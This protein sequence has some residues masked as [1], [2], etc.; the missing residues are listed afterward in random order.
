MFVFCGLVDGIV[1]EGSPGVLLVCEVRPT[2]TATRRPSM[3]VPEVMSPGLNWSE[4]T[5]TSSLGCGWVDGFG[6]KEENACD[7]VMAAGGF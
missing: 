7:C 4:P 1:V 6:R 3:M 2:S 5:D